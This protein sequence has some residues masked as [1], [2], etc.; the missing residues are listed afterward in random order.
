[1]PP[2][3]ETKKQRPHIRTSVR[4]VADIAPSKI[5]DVIGNNLIPR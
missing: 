4:Y 2:F 1:M 3:H 5:K